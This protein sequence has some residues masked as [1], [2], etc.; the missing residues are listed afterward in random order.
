MMENGPVDHVLA[1]SLNATPADDESEQHHQKY[2]RWVKVDPL[3]VVASIDS[4]SATPRGEEKKDTFSHFF[5]CNEEETQRENHLWNPEEMLARLAAL[6]VGDVCC[7]RYST[8]SGDEAST[9]ST[10]SLEH[11]TKQEYN[12]ISFG[13]ETD[14]EIMDNKNSEGTAERIT[15]DE[16]EQHEQPFSLDDDDHKTEQHK[17]S[18]NWI[19]KQEN[20][21]R[22]MEEMAR[23]MA[24]VVDQFMASN[25]PMEPL[26]TDTVTPSFNL[27]VGDGQDIDETFFSRSDDQRGDDHSRV[28][29]GDDDEIEQRVSKLIE[30]QEKAIHT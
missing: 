1:K 27:N 30:Q 3:Q 23:V 17:L 2:I 7:L 18:N 21:I 22:S 4:S 5:R 24:Q 26:S 29:N 6:V 19:E 12:L 28:N 15:F 20:A 9:V 13:G 8:N 10:C 16:E 14:D 25:I 11:E